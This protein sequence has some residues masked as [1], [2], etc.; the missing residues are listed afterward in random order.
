MISAVAGGSWLRI[1]AVVGATGCFFDAQP[2]RSRQSTSQDF[3]MP[4]VVALWRPPVDGNLGYTAYEVRMRAPE[5]ERVSPQSSRW[6]HSSSTAIPRVESVRRTPSG[7]HR[8]I[9]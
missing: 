7:A 5:R 3:L 1:G 4:L 2:A 8:S 6:Y 9:R